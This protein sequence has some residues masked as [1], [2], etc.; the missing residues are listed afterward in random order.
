MKL[1]WIKRLRMGSTN[2]GWIN[3][4][5]S[6]LPLNNNDF[7][8]CNFNKSSVKAIT[9]QYKSIPTFWADVILDWAEYN[10][11]TPDNVSDLV[12]QPLWFNSLLLNSKMK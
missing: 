9:K 10:F 7:W 1:S 4:V 12:L 2:I 3:I 8:L 11:Y 5:S 6:K